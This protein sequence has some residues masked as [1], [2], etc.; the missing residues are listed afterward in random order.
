MPI[1]SEDVLDV[2]L[3]VRVA[4]CPRG[5]WVHMGLSILPALLPNL[6][7]R[8]LASFPLALL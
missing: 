3:R 8:M 2:R 4:D 1:V 5:K 6:I 7:A